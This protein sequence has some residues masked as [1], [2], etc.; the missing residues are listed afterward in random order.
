MAR[1]KE[2]AMA[3]AEA[4]TQTLYEQGVPWEE[5]AERAQVEVF[6]YS[7]AT[8]PAVDSAYSV[9]KSEDTPK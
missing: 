8:C 6:G 3:L 9:F 4:L 1:V 7:T 5:A 2:W